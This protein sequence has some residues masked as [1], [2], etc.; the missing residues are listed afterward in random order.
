M[1]DDTT[2]TDDEERVDLDLSAESG[3]TPPDDAREDDDAQVEREQQAEPADATGGDHDPRDEAR[4]LIQNSDGRTQ[5][6]KAQAAEEELQ[7][8]LQ[9]LNQR[10]Q[11]LAQRRQQVET[12]LEH[13]LE[14]SEWMAG[15]LDDDH[16]MMLYTMEY[17]VTVDVPAGADRKD[18]LDRVE[19][20]IDEL[21]ETST[22]LASQAEQADE[23]VERV[24][25]VLREVQTFREMATPTEN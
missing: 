14:T 21:R 9:Q 4:R 24:Q 23:T 19:A 16:R 8:T 13:M 11:K 6:E 17:G 20:E 12:R 18:L 7:S 1:S 15:I 10:Q 22:K 5:H 2:T 25:G 3:E